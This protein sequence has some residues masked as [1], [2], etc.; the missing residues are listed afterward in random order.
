MVDEDEENPA[1]LDDKKSVYSNNLP[2]R[3]KSISAI[4]SKSAL[5]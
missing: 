3:A 2:N 5:K 1:I 4:S